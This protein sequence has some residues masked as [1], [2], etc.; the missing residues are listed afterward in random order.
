MRL[1]HIQQGLGIRQYSDW[2]EKKP[3]KEF[4]K[5]VGGVLAKML[6][7]NQEISDETKAIVDAIQKIGPILSELHGNEMI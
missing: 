3:I 7:S 2:M 1:L 6:K 5:V 4:W